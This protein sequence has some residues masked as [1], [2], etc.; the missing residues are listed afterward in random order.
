MAIIEGI[1][2]DRYVEA[3]CGI[4]PRAGDMFIEESINPKRHLSRG[5]G[6]DGWCYTGIRLAPTRTPLYR[7][8]AQWITS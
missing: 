4:V 2:I 7:K 8:D 5:W 6:E 1:I 3:Q